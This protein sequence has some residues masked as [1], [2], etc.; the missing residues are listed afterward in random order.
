MPSMEINMQQIRKTSFLK[1]LLAPR[2]QQAIEPK[3]PPQPL[4]ERQMAR[5]AGGMGESLP[6]GG[7]N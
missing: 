5:V 4:D 7:W 2:K 1:S 6:K 3:K